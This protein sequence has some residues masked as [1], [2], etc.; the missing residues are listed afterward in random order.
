MTAS[1][2]AAVE[3][4]TAAVLSIPA[5]APTPDTLPPTADPVDERGTETFPASAP[6]AWWAAPDRRGGASS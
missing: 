4:A 1:T 3:L 5:P 6:P 2:A